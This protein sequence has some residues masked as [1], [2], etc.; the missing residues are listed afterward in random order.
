MVLPK[1]LFIA[2]SW[3]FTTR[4]NFARRRAVNWVGVL[5]MKSEKNKPSPL[6]TPPSPPPPLSYSTQYQTNKPPT[7]WKIHFHCI[8]YSVF[9][10]SF[11]ISVYC[12]KL[13]L[14]PTKKKEIKRRTSPPPPPFKNNAEESWLF[15]SNPVLWKHCSQVSPGASGE[16][17]FR[18]TFREEIPWSFSLPFFQQPW[19]FLSCPKIFLLWRNYSSSRGQL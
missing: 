12:S 10:Q 1:W 11:A 19:D 14:I 8:P 6:S 4:V 18:K 15:Q 3:S 13:S 7:K 17:F 16:K 5:W 9:A 2:L